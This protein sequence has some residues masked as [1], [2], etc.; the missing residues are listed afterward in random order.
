MRG[1]DQGRRRNHRMGARLTPRARAP[2][3]GSKTARGITPC[4]T[5]FPVAPCRAC[6][7]RSGRG[8]PRRL[9]P[10]PLPPEGRCAGGKAGAPPDAPGRCGGE[11]FTQR[12][13]QVLRPP[14][15]G[16][17]ASTFRRV[18][19]PEEERARRDA[20]WMPCLR[21][22]RRKGCA[23]RDAR[24]VAR[25][26]SEPRRGSAAPLAGSAAVAAQRVGSFDG[27]RDG[28][29]RAARV[30][31]ARRGG[32]RGGRGGGAGARGGVR[33]RA[34]AGRPRADREVATFCELCFWNCGV[35]ARVRKNRVLA[36]KGHPRYPNA[37]GKLCGR[38]QAGAGFVVDED[39]L[40]Y[41][42]IRTGERGEGKFRRAGWNEAYA[43]IAEGFAKIKARYGAEALALF[44]HGSGGPLMRQMLVAYGSP[45]YA[46]PSYAQCKGARN[47]GYKLTFGEKL[48]SPEPIESREHALHG[49]LRVPPRRERPQLAGAGVRQ[50][51]R[52]G[53][54][55][56]GARPA[57]LD[58]R[59][60]GGRLAA[61]PARLR[62]R[63]DPGVAAPAREG[64]HVRRRVR[65]GADDRLRRRSRATSSRS[66]RSGRRSAPAS[67]PRRSSRPIA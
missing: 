14:D 54:V 25:D 15:R 29:D 10:T 26:F 17:A 36:L 23:R 63:G 45:N 21:A 22:L 8:L 53:R 49:V 60:E 3:A 31:E 35:V 20:E 48:V 28:E 39:R 65:E 7:T 27:R 19:I 43:V 37:N 34:G 42:M 24:L 32:R 18:D 5:A 33:P 59:V 1:G 58:G 64:G 38:G 13:P 56:R 57:A 67:R 61:D 6:V 62:H 4:A 50:G 52:P 40:K 47:V 11:K 55:A 30:P 51:A 41:P 2:G 12:H 9:L 66:R 16:P 44:Y 46:G